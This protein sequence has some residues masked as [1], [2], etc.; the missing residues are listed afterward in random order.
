MTE[1]VVLVCALFSLGLYGVLTRRELVGVLA[2]VEIM[3]GSANILLVG[4]AASS[5]EAAGV[6]GAA[7]AAGLAIVVVAAA[8]ASVGLA[9]LIAAVRR[10]GRRSIEE[11]TEVSG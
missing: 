1:L 4:L 7:E 3:L 2:S 9:L 6:P 5:S 11:F 10:S 8:E